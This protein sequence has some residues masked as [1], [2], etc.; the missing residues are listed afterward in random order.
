LRQDEGLYVTHAGSGSVMDGVEA[1]VPTVL[2]ANSGL[3]GNHQEE[4]VVKLADKGICV[5]GD[6]S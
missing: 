2:V 6:L 5:A 1:Q 3:M 4:L